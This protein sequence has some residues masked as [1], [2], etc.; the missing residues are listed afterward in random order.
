MYR[1][2]RYKILLLIFYSS[3]SA[4]S[5]DP[6]SI[7][8]VRAKQIIKNYNSQL[9]ML[10]NKNNSNQLQRKIVDG[11]ISDYFI[12]EDVR[13]INDLNKKGGS[14]DFRAKEYL[15]YIYILKPP[16][17]SLSYECEDDI[18]ALLQGKEFKFQYVKVKRIIKITGDKSPIENIEYLYFCF[19][20]DEKTDDLKISSIGNK[21]STWAK[22]PPAKTIIANAGKFS[23][24]TIKT[25]PSNA[26]I[27]IDGV[28][29]QPK[30]AMT[31]SITSGKIIE[32]ICKSENY[33]DTIHKLVVNANNYNILNINLRPIVGSVE[34]NSE[35]SGANVFIDDVKVGSTPY[36]SSNI[37]I[38]EHQIKF[39]KIGNGK[40]ET[41][42]IVTKGEKKV[43]KEILPVEKVVTFQCNDSWTRLF[44]DDRQIGIMPQTLSL[45]YGKHHIKYS[46]SGCSDKSFAV[47]V[48]QNTDFI[49]NSWDC[50]NKIARGDNR[51][52][53]RDNRRY[54]TKNFFSTISN[55]FIGDKVKHDICGGW[56]YNYGFSMAFNRISNRNGGFNYLIDYTNVK[57]IPI[58]L[59]L[60]WLVG[61]SYY[62]ISSDLV[63]HYF[64][65]GDKTTL[66]FGGGLKADNITNDIKPTLRI[67]IL[68]MF[69]EEDEGGLSYYYCKTIGSPVG[70]HNITFSTKKHS[71]MAWGMPL[72]L[73]ALSII[74][75]GVYSGN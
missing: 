30:G 74:P 33:Y 67:G 12:N 72:L 32:I 64:I 16:I 49:Y 23:N 73:F 65:K 1:K 50:S 8:K 63:M 2:F 57:K 26:E 6:V 52:A 10:C 27:I 40:L 14:K 7:Y 66:N 70:V 36:F 45:S 13:I 4:Q 61:K 54:A 60:G 20:L 19:R 41:K 48:N 11:I 38:G 3:I 21:D 68:S 53:N 75:F 58:S 62:S 71:E 29:Y 24:V 17:E 15:R 9:N 51:H 5:T 37:A 25:V 55:G 34:L 28:K 47:E 31:L 43:L 46:R 39:E 69:G 42:I 44:V 59:Q 22:Y 18:S 56:H 35:P